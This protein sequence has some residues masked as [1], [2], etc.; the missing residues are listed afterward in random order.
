MLTIHRR[1]FLLFLIISFQTSF[2]VMGQGLFSILGEY[3]VM[4][5]FYRNTPLLADNYYHKAENILLE[6]PPFLLD[7]SITF[8]YKKREAYK[9]EQLFADNVN[10]V[11]FLGGWSAVKNNTTVA[12]ISKWDLA[13]R[14]ENGKIQYRWNLIPAR[15]DPIL[16]MGYTSPNIVLDN[17]PWCFPEIPWEPTEGEGFGQASPPHDM[18]EWEK[19]IAD[20]CNELVHRY[21]FDMVNSWGFRLGTEAGG[22]NRFNGTDEQYRTFYKSTAKAVTGVLPGARIFPYNRAGLGHEN[23]KTLL[24]ECKKEGIKYSASTISSYSIARFDETTGVLK[25]NNM[26]PDLTANGSASKMWYDMDAITDPSTLTR[27]IHEYGWFLQ[28]EFGDGDNAPG[29][30]GAAGNFHY[31]MNLRQKRLDKLFHWSVIGPNG[32]W[33]KVILNSQGFI[34]SVWDY[35][36]GAR[37]VELNKTLKNTP[38]STQMYKS[39]GYFHNNGKSYIMVS[40]YNMDRKQKDRNRIS[41]YIPKSEFYD[42]N[43][44]VSYTTLNDSTDHYRMLRDDLAAKSVLY[45]RYANDADY[46]PQFNTMS[47]QGKWWLQKDNEKYTTRIKENLT[48]KPFNGTVQVTNEGTIISF[49]IRTPELFVLALKKGSLFDTKNIEEQRT[50]I[51]LYPNPVKDKFIINSANLEYAEIFSADGICVMQKNLKNTVNEVNIESLSAG[52]YFLRLQHNGVI[53]TERLIKQ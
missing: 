18:N 17:T 28:N 33:Q 32:E 13:Y 43:V 39:V 5:R 35:C 11:R 9:Y 50:A 52:V 12:E 16:Q 53:S 44:V 24:S 41:V 14:D 29:A 30:R 34:F 22:L 6:V 23:L 20:L 25:T 49:E 15:I 40:G 46:V 10:I 4:D 45:D 8:R 36:I 47:A 51:S 37:T 21:G 42:P 2:L 19:F 27:E 3:P 26:N 38:Q 7:E 48:L 1:Y 31:I